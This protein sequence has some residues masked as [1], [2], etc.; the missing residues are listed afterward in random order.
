[1]RQAIRISL[2]NGESIDMVPNY[3]V[4]PNKVDG[5]IASDAIQNVAV[6]EAMKA[7]RTASQ[8]FILTVVPLL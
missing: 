3:T 6:R 5:S 1:M 4:R 7:I 2:P 8:E